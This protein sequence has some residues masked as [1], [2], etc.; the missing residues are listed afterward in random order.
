[1]QDP[2]SDMLTRVRNGQ[3]A[4]KV[5]VK[6]PSSKLKVAIAALLKA[7]GYIGIKAECPT[8]TEIIITGCDKQVVGQVAADIRSYRQPEPYKGKGVR[9]ADE[10][11]IAPNGSEVI[12]AA[13]TVEKAIREQIGST[14]NKAAAEAIGKLIAERAIEKGITNVAFDRSGFQYHG[15]V[16]ALA[17]SAREAGLKF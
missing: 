12:A 11:V 2:I 1:M 10:I 7:E 13:S 14:S 3:S 4:N 16:A 6:M 9:Y 5:A 8:Q 17:D 15:R